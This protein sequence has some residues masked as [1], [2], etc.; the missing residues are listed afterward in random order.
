MTGVKLSRLGKAALGYADHGWA[1]FPL[2]PRDKA[3]HSGLPER[4]TG[5][6]GFKFATTDAEQIARWWTE[7][8]D[9]N[10]GLAPGRAGL[11]VIDV[12]GGEGEL[13]A[14]GFGLYAEP[15]LTCL[16]CRSDGGRHLYFRHPG[17]HVG[18]SS[19]EHLE[20]RADSGYALLP[21]SVHP[22]GGEYR[23]DRTTRE[24][25][26]LPPK[27]M[28]ALRRQPERSPLHL[29]DLTNGLRD[30]VRHNTLRTWIARWV[31]KGL[32]TEEVTACALAVNA[33]YGRPP[34]DEDEIV[35]LVGWAVEKEDQS[36]AQEVVSLSRWRRARSAS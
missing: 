8:S 23:W 27:V 32:G 6:G 25:L 18:N 33:H 22:N 5:Y 1:I 2:E 34:T 11:I 31:A 3:P 7:W 36:G 15:T 30:G 16:T 29:G 21:P 24:I 28:D 35:C 17:F 9:A 14:Q 13:A 4:H 12:D 20:M 10:I 26:A 19:L